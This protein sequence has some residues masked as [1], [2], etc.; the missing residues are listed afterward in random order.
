MQYLSA[1]LGIVTGRSLPEV[2]GDRL[3]RTGRLAY[4]PQAE[5]VTMATDIAGVLGGSIALALLFDLPLL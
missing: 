1:K 3:P 4:W 2:L 5:L